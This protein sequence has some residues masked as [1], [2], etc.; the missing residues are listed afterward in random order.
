MDLKPEWFY[1]LNHRAIAEAAIALAI[2]GGPV[3]T[4]TVSQ[5]LHFPESTKVVSDCANSMA[6]GFDW[7]ADILKGYATVR[8]ILKT[9]TEMAATCY[10]PL[11][12]EN[13][14]EILDHF[15][16]AALGIREEAHSKGCNA[17]DLKTCL[18]EVIEE[19][20]IAA[21]QQK[22]RGLETG[23]GKLDAILG[24]MK[25]QELFIVAARPSVGKTSL[26]MNIAD[27]LAVDNSVPVGVFSLEMS[28]KELI[29]RL[30]CSRSEVDLGV[31][32]AGRGTGHELSNIT[33]QMDKIRKSPLYIVD[34]GGLSLPR[35]VSA[36]RRLLQRHKIEFLIVDYLGLI[37]S[38][39]KGQT[40]YEATST[41]SN[42]LK[43]IAKEL[44]IPVL[45]LCQLNRSP[46]KDGRA[47]NLHDLRDS[48]A[49]E[50]DA[51]AV[52]LLHRHPQDRKP[53]E[54]P[55]PI[56][57]DCIVAKH[58]NGA[59]GYVELQFSPHFTK[60]SESTGIPQDAGIKPRKDSYGDEC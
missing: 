28:T 47:P 51:D 22:P 53:N 34:K 6:G 31:M 56:T 11:A 60:F 48:G 44:D 29:A 46:E 21:D 26:A 59:T 10:D 9:S 19:W 8:A 37:S 57:V 17:S 4:Y 39:V 25:P 54:T 24:G 42:G 16:Q 2:D 52:I 45:A 43:L 15:E 55:K 49:I 1:V 23:F 38:G 12:A 5:R 50:Q 3:D 7:W 13:A 27:Y 40:R 35:L 36:S 20:R 30:T 14:D 33:G 58:R 18:L 41:V 32:N